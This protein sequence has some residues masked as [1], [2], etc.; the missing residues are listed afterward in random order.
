[1]ADQT[2]TGPE[3]G[4]EPLGGATS[5]GAAAGSEG[6][7]TEGLDETLGATGA[8]GGGANGGTGSGGTGG[9][10]NFKEQAGQF[11]R[12]AGDKARQFADTGKSRAGDAL[13]EVARLM[14]DAA[15]TVEQKLGGQYGQYARSA[16]QGLGNFSEELKA[17]DIDEL[18][19]DAQEF[20]RKSPAVAIG[21]AAAL[22]FVIARV[23]KAGGD[24]DT[25]A[26]GGTN[27]TGA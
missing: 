24:G 17:K 6:F 21:V 22:G 11:A 10:G 20:I 13:G 5:G 9:G 12:Q 1:M 2:Q 4:S 25:T 27:G 8:G 3:I 7:G 23:V 19:G 18:I 14:E 15:G 16:A 26:G